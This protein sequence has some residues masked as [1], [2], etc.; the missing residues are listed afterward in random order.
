MRVVLGGVGLLYYHQAGAVTGFLPCSLA[1]TLAL[2]AVYVAANA[3]LLVVNRRLD[4]FQLYGAVVMLDLTMLAVIV[5]QD[6]Y[7]ASPVTILLLSTV[8]DYGRSPNRLLFSSVTLLILLILAVNAYARL[9]SSLVGFPPEGIWLS[10][11]VGLLILN[12]YFTALSAAEARAERRRLS[13]EVN[14]LREREH[15]A[16]AAQLRAAQLG[17]QLRF[18]GL[19]WDQFAQHGL[20]CLAREFGI[21]AGALYR[22]VEDHAGAG[23][24]AAAGYAVDPQQLPRRRVA[25]DQGLLGTCA[26]DRRTIELHPVPAGYFEIVSALGQVSPSHLYIFP[27][28][29]QARLAAVMELALLQPLPPGEVK[30]LEQLAETF[31]AG[32]AAAAAVPGQKPA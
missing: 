15:Q 20:G 17:E 5:L 11:A 4:P 29:F 14:A 19:P 23:L 28:H 7:P 13:T 25:L 32:L 10:L 1:A 24:V 9:T 27:V 22:R 16:I 18:N 26:R 21:C 30:L 31:A 6:P 2:I 12:Y 3:L 8:L